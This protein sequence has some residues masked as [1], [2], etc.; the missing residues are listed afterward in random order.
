MSG[1]QIAKAIR[2]TVNKHVTARR[3]A[4]PLRLCAVMRAGIRNVNRLVELAVR[5]AR[6]E[7]IEAF[8]SFVVSLARLGTNRIATQRNFVTLDYF[9][10]VDQLQGPVLLE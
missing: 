5:V 8:G 4:V 6:I 3:H 10:M 7:H 2:Q 1:A 9:S